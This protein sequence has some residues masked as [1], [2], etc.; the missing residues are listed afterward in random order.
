[1]SDRKSKKS[2]SS[3]LTTTTAAAAGSGA[4]TRFVAPDF[5]RRQLIFDSFSK[6]KRGNDTNSRS[7]HVIE[8]GPKGTL[9]YTWGAGYHGQ[10]GLSSYRKKCKHVPA[11]IEFKDSVL[12]VACGGF[13]TAVLT[14]SGQIWT[15][16]DGRYGQLGNLAR[17]H[18]MLATPHLVDRL[19]TMGVSAEQLSCGQYHTACVSGTLSIA[20][21][22]VYL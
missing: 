3:A 18:N 17:K 14:G 15:W 2:K 22:S 13:H 10:L 12:Q 7:R 1:M 9:L 6:L 8:S 19:V 4:N 21:V 20:L 5:K 11:M 16:G